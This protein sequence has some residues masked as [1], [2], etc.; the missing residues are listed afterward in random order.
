VDVHQHADGRGGEELVHVP[1]GISHGFEDEDRLEEEVGFVGFEH[2]EARGAGGRVDEEVD[3]VGDERVVGGDEADVFAGDGAFAA[4][5]RQHAVAWDRRETFHVGVGGVEVEVALFELLHVDAKMIEDVGEDLAGG[6]VGVGGAHA[7]EDLFGDVAVE[8]IQ[9]EEAVA[10]FLELELEV[11]AKG[12]GFGNEGVELL[13]GV[14]FE[15]AFTVGGGEFEEARAEGF[16]VVVAAVE[17]RLEGVQAEMIPLGDGGIGSAGKIGD[18][19]LN[20]IRLANTVEA[21]DALL[22]EA[23]VEREIPENEVVGELE[24]APFAADFGTEEDLRAGGFCE[25]GG[26]AVALHEREALVEE[27][28]VEVE[29]FFDGGFEGEDLALGA[30]DEK[31]FG[32]GGFFEEGDKPV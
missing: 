6:R 22:D 8:G 19:N 5:G 26:L 15:A 24:V 23:R 28:D 7:I 17:R 27:A 32:G 30:A 21:A 4:V 20:R 25:P 29:L 16:G 12:F 14:F 3:A 31:D 1:L 2:A 9:L 18:V 11:G 13:A 10:T